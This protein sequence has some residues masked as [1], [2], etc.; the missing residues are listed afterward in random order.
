MHPNIYYIMSLGP[1]WDRLYKQLI[2]TPLT[3]QYC[4]YYTVRYLIIPQ[5]STFIV[6]IHVACLNS[7][8]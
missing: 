1:L 6:T 2:Y 4:C 5:S 3:Q 8:V 7:L